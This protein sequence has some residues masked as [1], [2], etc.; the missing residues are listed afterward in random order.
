MF[1]WQEILSSKVKRNALA[2]F[3]RVI[4]GIPLSF[5]FTYFVLKK[6]S[7]SEYGIWALALTFFSLFGFF[8]FGLS[9]AI[10]RFTAFYQASQK[11]KKVNQIV[12]TTLAFY[13]GVGL[14]ITIS[15]L[16]VESLIMTHF[17]K[18]AVIAG[19]TQKL[20][21]RL[22]IIAGFFTFCFGT[23][24][25]LLNGFQRMDLTN[26][27]ELLKT[28][29]F[30]FLGLVFLTYQASLFHL[31]LAYLFTL[32]IVNFINL[33]FCQRS[34]PKLSLNLV[35]FNKKLLVKMLKFGF[36]TQFS[37]FGFFIHWNFDKLIIGYFLGPEKVGFLDIAL[38]LINQARQLASS[39]VSPLLP[40]AAEKT[41]IATKQVVKFYQKSFRYVAFSSAFIFGTLFIFSPLLVKLW[42]GEGFEMT[43][44][45]TQILSFGHFFN[46]LTGPG[47]SV[48]LAQNKPRILVFSSTFA[49]LANIVFSLIGIYYLGFYG[50]ILGTTAS[51]VLV[52]SLYIYLFPKYFKTTK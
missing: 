13:F 9:P 30:T 27:S 26:F 35:F 37:G 40:A 29:L 36:Q 10:T 11:E 31:T 5:F 34:F 15:L 4:L 48:L 39:F 38:K 51:L 45:A 6:L 43:A 28:I 7:L 16:L 17:F 8:D 3:A 49:A 46:M 33:F 41:A 44:K 12:I 25:S 1:T 20:V 23:F 50:A 32:V 18:T 14:I 2:N 19:Q 52:D 42:L 47:A 22:M 21:Y 24:T